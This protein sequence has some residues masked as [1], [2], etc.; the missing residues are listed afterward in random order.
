MRADQASREKKRIELENQ[1]GKRANVFG[2]V[3]EEKE[4]MYMDTISSSN[5]HIKEP[6]ADRQSL[7]SHQQQQ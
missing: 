1:I 2:Q 6:T 3:L 5:M 4:K 7:D